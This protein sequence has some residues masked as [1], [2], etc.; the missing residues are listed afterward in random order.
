[1]PEESHLRTT[2]L[3]L[4]VVLLGVSSVLRLGI[5]CVLLSYTKDTEG[6]T[7][8]VLGLNFQVSGESNNVS[9]QLELCFY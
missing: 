4:S 3:E 1:M 5:F 8:E 2:L 9:R 6:E 7:V